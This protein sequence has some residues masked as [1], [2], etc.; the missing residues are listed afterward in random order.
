MKCKYLKRG[1]IG[2]LLLLMSACGGGNLG[3]NPPPSDPVKAQ[4]KI[5]AAWKEYESARY[6]KAITL[7]NEARVLDSSL[8]DI[9]NGLGWSHFKIH[10]LLTSLQNFSTAFSKD[11]SMTEAMVGYGVSAF[12]KMEYTKAIKVLTTITRKDSLK[13][14]LVGTDEFVFKHDPS[15]TS[16]KVRKILALSYFYSGRFTEAYIQL[17]QYL[18]PGTR[19]VPESD[20]F[21]KD[22]LIALKSV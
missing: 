13:F 5:D 12:E 1:S 10:D 17:K 16:R 15:V 14:N 2:F 20:T 6:Y 8:L 3:V 22:L 19:V 21:V 9:Y 11:S 7:F 18:D 4:G